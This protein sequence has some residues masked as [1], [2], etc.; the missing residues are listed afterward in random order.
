MLYTPEGCRK[1][2]LR[3][4]L[5]ADI[6]NG[7]CAHGQSPRWCSPN[8]QGHPCGPFPME[9]SRGIQ[10]PHGYVEIPWD[11][12]PMAGHQVST[13]SESLCPGGTSTGNIATGMLFDIAPGWCATLSLA[14]SVAWTAIQ[15]RESPYAPPVH[16]GHKLSST[17][18]MARAH[19]F[20]LAGMLLIAIT[21]KERFSVRRLAQTAI[22]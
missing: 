20:P 8:G 16:S 9:V 5:Q 19:S 15:H 7:R 14:A 3:G 6:L 2:T 11:L 21:P 1:R 17:D 18:G 4:A 10:H 13:W 22:F 12:I